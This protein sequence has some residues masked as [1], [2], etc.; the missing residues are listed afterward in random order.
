M[1]V[2]GG[3]GGGGFAQG[4]NLARTASGPLTSLAGDLRFP[5]VQF[6]KMGFDNSR[7]LWITLFSVVY[8]CIYVVYS[9]R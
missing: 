8:R 2:L 5:L 9:R 4:V 6:R 7:L 3:G 1:L